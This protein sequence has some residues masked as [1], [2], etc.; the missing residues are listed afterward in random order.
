MEEQVAFDEKSIRILDLLEQV[1]KVNAMID[2]HQNHTLDE[3]MIRQYKDIKQ[4]FLSELK[5]LL[6]E[7]QIEVQINNETA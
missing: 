3:V 1:K 6:S 7:F 4:Q 2:L 5:D